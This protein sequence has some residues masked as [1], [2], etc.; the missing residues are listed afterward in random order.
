MPD[1]VTIYHNPKCS[2]SRETLALLK[3]RG[4]EPSVVEYLSQ[5]PTREELR[6]ILKKLGAKPCDII[7]RNEKLFS[8]LGLGD[9][10]DDALIVAMVEHPALMERPIVVKGAKA[11]VGRPPKNV[12]EIL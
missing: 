8:E 1:Q 11:A 10:T 4:V 2:K 6:D 5:T 9:A 3:D 7:R 12:L